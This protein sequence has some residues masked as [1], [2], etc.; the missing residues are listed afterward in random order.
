[1]LRKW[2]AHLEVVREADRE[3]EE[4]RVEAG[5]ELEG[6]LRYPGPKRH[7]NWTLPMQQEVNF[8]TYTCTIFEESR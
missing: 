5:G 2:R 3:E 6:D 8:I 4:A 1:M 7:S